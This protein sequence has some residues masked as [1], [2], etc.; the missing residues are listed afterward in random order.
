MPFTGTPQPLPN[1]N[2]FPKMHPGVTVTA[3]AIADATDALAAA[4]ET[5]RKFGQTKAADL[6]QSRFHAADTAAAIVFVGEVKRGKSTLVNALIG[7]AD[8]APVGVDIT[9]SASVWFSPPDEL[10]PAGSARLMF[11]DTT[12]V[13]PVDEL[14]EWVT[15]GGRHVLDPTI[16]SLPTE[17]VVAV[18]P[19]HLPGLTL[20]DTPGAGGLDPRHA[21][22]ALTAARRAG[23]IVMVCDSAAPL[24][25]PE[26]EFLRTATETSGSVVV[27]MTKID[28][29][30][31]N[32]RTIAEENRSIVRSQLGREVQVIGVSG[33]RALA[34]LQEPANTRDEILAASGIPALRD[35]INGLLD[36]A[37]IAPMLDGLQVCRSGMHRMK[38]RLDTE[39]SLVQGDSSALDD[40]AEKKARLKALREHG[41][42]WDQHLS[43]DITLAR[44]QA[45]SVLDA[46]FN[47]IKED[48]SERINGEG[49][50]ILRKQPQVFTAAIMSDVQAASARAFDNFATSLHN[51]VS[52]LFGN[53]EQWED[54]M[55]TVAGALV[56]EDI[57]SP[58]V[59]RRWKDVVDPSAMMMGFMG[60]NL[61]TGGMVG[62]AIFGSLAMAA[63]LPIGLVAG[64]VWLSVNLGYRAMRNGRQHL[65][66]WLRETLSLANKSTLRVIDR[67]VATARPEIVVAYRRHLR[68]QTDEITEQINAGAEAAKE[69]KATRDKRVRGLTRR[70][71]EIVSLI[72]QLD[73]AIAGLK[74]DATGGTL[75]LGKDPVLGA[76]PAPVTGTP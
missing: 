49:W 15:M 33:V 67:T 27:A 40:L 35:A 8:L 46:D 19:L 53:D 63:V 71:T 10:L 9:T 16:E 2:P 13:I 48:W 18:D 76:D 21:R 23:A 44:Q 47:K 12:Q 6:A 41:T 65:I 56:A 22:L 1:A 62:G 38:S 68:T 39:I 42:E 3:R 36:H 43:R 24:T 69:D 30:R 7:Q 61:L 55:D 28:K 29:N 14:P 25:A 59:Q 37:E 58:E 17:A 34:A 70:L 5:L 32:W 75:S 64:G 66:T 57:N 11:A 73:A 26:I 31:R 50:R 52:R 20:V 51:I 4:T 72:E 54:I 45:I 60:A 74:A